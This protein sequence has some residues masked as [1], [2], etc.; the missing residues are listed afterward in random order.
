MVLH[1]PGG[2]ALDRRTLLTG[3]VGT[4]ATAI[5]GNPAAASP[6]ASTRSGPTDP[7]TLEPT[8]TLDLPGLAEAVTDE[9]GETVF[10]AVRDGF[11]IVDVSDPANPELLAEERDLTHE[12]AG[13][14]QRIYDVKYDDDRLV[15]AGPNAGGSD[16]LVG[17]FLYDVSDPATPERLAF[18]GTSHAIHNCHLDGDR[19]YLTGGT[20]PG[21]PAV[22]YD[23]AGDDPEKVGAWSA[24]QE[25]DIWTRVGSNYLSCHDLYA[26]G[27]TLYVAYWDAGTWVVDVSDPATP[28]ALARLGGLDPNYLAELDRGSIAEF[29]ELPGNSHYVQPNADSDA[30]FVGKE[31]WDRPDTDLDGGPGGIECWSMGEEP[32]RESIIQSPAG[33]DSNATSHNF[34]LRNDRLYASWYAGGVAVYDVSDRAAPQVLGAWRDDTAASFWT[35][36]PLHEGFLGASHAN[37][38]NDQEARRTGE[39]AALYLFPEPESGGEPA[40]LMEPRPSPA[41]KATGED[42]DGDPGGGGTDQSGGSGAGT[43]V[44]AGGETTTG[45]DDSTDG[46]SAVPGFGVGAAVTAVGASLGLARL[47][48]R[49]QE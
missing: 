40:P 6:A 9:A 10:C 16:D 13:P 17:F 22:I 7:P 48:G 42:G 28:T 39:G 27:D 36:K 20:T 8:A 14:M 26:R 30:V 19:V 47:F 32:T 41:T 11:A 29:I 49:Q 34:G 23:I 15:V 1:N 45:P 44:S 38:S 18:Q 21:S 31:A 46:E 25:A 4:A 3:V 2:P 35:A 24:T 33:P 37:P 43:T 5:A 12:D